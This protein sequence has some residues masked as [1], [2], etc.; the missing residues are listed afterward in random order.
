MDKLDKLL[1]NVQN[2]SRYIGGEIN[3][4]NKEITEGMVRFVLAFPDIYE[5][6]MSYLGFQILYNLKNER[7]DIFCERVFSPWED[8]ENE[9]RKNNME[10]FTLESKTPLKEMD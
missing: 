10:L 3:S 7:D 2:P 6:G 5:I 4:Y 9:L 8:M 1:R